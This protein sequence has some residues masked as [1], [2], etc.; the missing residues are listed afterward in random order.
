MYN[1]NCGC[2]LMYEIEYQLLIFH[3]D[4]WSIMFF[5]CI[6]LPLS[7]PS[8]LQAC[9]ACKYRCLQ[10][11]PLHRSWS[12]CR[13]TVTVNT[14]DQTKKCKHNGDHV[15]CYCYRLCTWCGATNECRLTDTNSH[16]NL[17]SCRWKQPISISSTSLQW[18]LTVTHTDT[19]SYT[20]W[21]C[22]S[23]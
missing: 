21:L 13:A 9:Y 7:P 23:V 16:G 4:Q 2:A 11:W 1:K 10:K 19:H 5:A 20:V 18:V 15:E 6:C 14:S 22:L 12:E 17:S 8:P 3:W